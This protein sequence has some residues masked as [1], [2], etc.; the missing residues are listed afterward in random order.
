MLLKFS[1]IKLKFM[2]I[3]KDGILIKITLGPFLR[4]AAYMIL[5]YRLK[6]QVVMYIE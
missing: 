6:E 3:Q 4:D 1:Q 5:Q 2:D